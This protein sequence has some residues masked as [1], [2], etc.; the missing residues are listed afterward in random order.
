MVIDEQK[1]QDHYQIRGY[2][3][4][5]VTINTTRYTQSLIIGRQTLIVPWRP[6]R[7]EEIIPEDWEAVFAQSPQVVLVGTGPRAKQPPPEWNAHFH[8]RHIGVE[9]MDTGAACRTFVALASEKRGVVAALL[10]Q[11][12]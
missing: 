9:W 4:E 5:S 10:L 2:D 11:D 7:F 12:Q 6:T 8:A 3:Q 1:S